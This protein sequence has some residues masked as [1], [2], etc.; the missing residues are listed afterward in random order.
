MCSGYSPTQDFAAPAVAHT[1]SVKVAFAEAVHHRFLSCRLDWE[2]DI[3]G[4]L[5][6]ARCNSLVLNLTMKQESAAGARIH[7]NAVRLSSTRLPSAPGEIRLSQKFEYV[8]PISLLLY[9]LTSVPQVHFHSADTTLCCHCVTNWVP[10]P[11]KGR[12]Q[13]HFY[14]RVVHV[15]PP[16]HGIATA[17]ENTRPSSL[18]TSVIPVFVVH[19]FKVDFHTGIQD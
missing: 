6:Q 18:C 5:L 3:H 1:L 17:G 11:T 16:F 8:L 19:V 12:L 10:C 9:P 14:F 2:R 4:F 7:W 13:L 15:L